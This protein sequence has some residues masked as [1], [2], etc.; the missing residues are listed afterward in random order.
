MGGAAVAEEAVGIGIGV[1]AERLGAGH[2]GF[3]EAGED[4]GFEVE[5]VMALAA[6]REEA[7]VAPAPPRRSGGGRRR[8]PR[9]LC[10]RSPGRSRRRSGSRSAPRSSIAATVASITP[11]SAPFQPAWAAPITPA[12]RSA[13]RTGVQSAVRMP[14]AR[15]GRSVTIAS[16][17]RAGVVGPGRVGVERVGRMDLVDGDQPRARARPPR[18]RG[19]GSR[20]SR[21]DRRPSRSRR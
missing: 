14:S 11:P 9:R 13:S 12:S 10:A 8:P 20:R 17:W 18:P 15:P 4:I 3:G 7:L 5:L 6:R 16:A 2:A 21:R 19:G 1:E